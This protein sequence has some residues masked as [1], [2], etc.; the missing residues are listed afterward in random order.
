MWMKIHVDETSGNPLAD[1]LYSTCIVT[2][3][4]F[5]HCHETV[6]SSVWKKS[7]IVMFFYLFLRCWKD[8]LLNEWNRLPV[9]LCDY[10]GNS[11]WRT[12]ESKQ[13]IVCGGLR[14]TRCHPTF[15]RRQRPTGFVNLGNTAPS[16]PTTVKYYCAYLIDRR[17]IDEQTWHIWKLLFTTCQH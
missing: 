1:I 13:R 16:M 17:H 10:G 6:W 11:R 5:P 15:P 12:A 7:L 14:T 2:E 9:A 4:F 8:I 3:H